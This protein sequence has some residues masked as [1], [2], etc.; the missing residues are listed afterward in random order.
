VAEAPP[1]D[2]W[3]EQLL[4]IQQSIAEVDGLQEQLDH[5]LA[6]PQPPLSP[7][8]APAPQT[9]EDTERAAYEESKETGRSP[10]LTRPTTRVFPFGREVPTLLCVPDR[11]CD[12]E[13]EAGEVVDGLA[14]GDASRWQVEQFFE[15]EAGALKPHLLLKPIEFGLRTNAV[16]V[17][18]RRT[19]HLELE[20]T[21]ETEDGDGAEA[22]PYH[23]H[24]AF[25]YPERWARRLRTEEQRRAVEQA[26]PTAPALPDPLA[27]GKLRFSYRIEEPRRKTHRLPWQPVTIF[28]D[29]ASTYLV[30]PPEAH[31]S[32]LPVLLGRL[33]DGGHFPLNATLHGDWYVVPTLVEEM[34]LVRG[35]GR[36]RRWLSI[37]R[38]GAGAE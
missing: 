5:Q 8:P 36:E 30:L 24:V 2:P 32:P 20:A 22:T 33:P 15:G 25:W 10:I 23:H 17:T 7:E 35:A 4:Q 21:E 31:E 9:W 37:R 1:P 29:G 28:D 26:Q 16:V 12:V 6:A 13:L 38:T 3:T 11:A 14:L 27:A 34:E 19:Y 18:N